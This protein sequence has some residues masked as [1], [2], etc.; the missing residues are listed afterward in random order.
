MSKI[1]YIDILGDTF[2]EL[3]VTELSNYTD[4]SQN[5]F[6][7]CKCSCGKFVTVRGSDLRCNRRTNCGCIPRKRYNSSNE[8]F[9]GKKFGEWTVIKEVINKSDLHH[10]YWMCQCKCGK[11]SNIRHDSVRNCKT[12]RCKAYSYRTGADNPCWKGYE[13]ISG[14]LFGQIRSNAIIRKL[15]FNLTPKYLWEQ[16]LRQ[17]KRCVYTNEYLTFDKKSTILA[18]ASLDRID[19]SKGYIIGNVQWVNRSVNTVKWDLPEKEFIQKCIAIANN[20]NSKYN[21]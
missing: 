17:D 6:W 12:T 21:G 10:R 7:I 14:Q 9:I 1:K 5:K 11:C 2:G 13:E 4:L 16:Y 3:T 15:E 20:Y 18:I 8:D 19:S